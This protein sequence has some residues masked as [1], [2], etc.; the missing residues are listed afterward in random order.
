[1]DPQHVNSELAS[2]FRRHS[3]TTKLSKEEYSYVDSLL[4]SQSSPTKN[5]LS[6]FPRVTPL[7]FSR[8]TPFTSRVQSA[9]ASV[10][11]SSRKH[12]EIF[13]SAIKTS[14]PSF[15]NLLSKINDE[16]EVTSESIDEQKSSVEIEENSVDKGVEIK[17]QEISEIS[18]GAETQEMT[19]AAKEL[20]A[21][22]SMNI[23]SDEKEPNALM[24]STIET[25]SSDLKFEKLPEFKFDLDV[26]LK[27]E[28]APKYQSPELPQ[29]TFDFDLSLYPEDHKKEN[30]FSSLPTFEFKID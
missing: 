21:S 29:Y 8:E 20:L 11:R 9:S 17:N 30:S 16:I 25:K 18:N 3:K 1:M 2:F 6:A 4:F 15:N 27:P 7:T 26:V 22:I 23:D 10:L 19:S 14:S 28:N 5:T 12:L 13:D 24:S